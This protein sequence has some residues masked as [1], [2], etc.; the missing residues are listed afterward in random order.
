MTAE[1]LPEQYVQDAFHSYLKSS[2]TQAKMEGLLDAEM[3]SSAEAD[4]MITGPALCLYFAALRCTTNPPSVPLPSISESTSPKELTISN[5]PSSF[6]TFLHIWSARVPEIQN[7][8]REYQRDLARIICDIDPIFDPSEKNLRGLAAD[9]RTVAIQ[10]SQR[11]SFQERYGEDLQ[12]AIDSGSESS[13]AGTTQKAHFVPPPMY[14]P[15][16]TTMSSSQDTSS[17]PAPTIDVAASSHH[18]SVLHAPA[19]HSHFHLSPFSIFHSHQ[20][21]SDR[22]KSASSS[23]S[24]DHS[25]A[26]PQHSLRSRSA[27]PSIEIAP[28]LYLPL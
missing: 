7:L 26:Q 9:L 24:S 4:L 11:R 3:L 19:P 5:C 27:S 1:R 16:P 10:I 25:H 17:M 14:E 23:R 6:T 2:L 18:T 22:P 8:P 12:V 28:E 21:P 20:S 15:S 13:V